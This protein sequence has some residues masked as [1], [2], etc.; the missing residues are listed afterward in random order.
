MLHIFLCRCHN[1]IPTTE[2]EIEQLQKLHI[3]LTF[4]KKSRSGVNLSQGTDRSAS[5]SYI[6]K[7]DDNG[8]CHGNQ[9]VIIQDNYR[10]GRLRSHVVNSGNFVK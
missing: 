8:N 4:I 7:N 1:Y 10:Q 2:W 5:T 9:S 6:E 3:F